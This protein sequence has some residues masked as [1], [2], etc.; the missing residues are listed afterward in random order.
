[1]RR[2]VAVGLLMA[3]AAIAQAGPTTI[4]AEG[5]IEADSNVQRLEPKGMEQPDP[6]P[7]PEEFTPA[8]ERTAAPVARLGAK[9]SHR[10]RVLNGG[11]AVGFGAL[12][13]TVIPMGSDSDPDLS[14]ENVVLLSGDFRWM[15]RIG[16]RAVSAGFDLIGIDAIPITDQYGSRTFRTLGGDALLALHGSDDRTLTFA[17]GGRYFKYKP[18]VGTDMTTGELLFGDFDWYGPTASVRLDLDLWRDVSGASSLEVS[19][20]FG[21]EARAYR[22]YALAYNCG[23]MPIVPDP[24]PSADADRCFAPTNLKRNDRYQR[25]ALELTWTGRVVAAAT[26][27]ISVTDSNSYGQS[28]MRHRATLSA[29]T[30]LPWSLHGTALATLQFDRYP[31]GLPNQDLSTL[32]FLSIDDENRS[33]LQARIARRISATWSI[34]TRG[35]IWRDLGSSPDGTFR[36]SLLYVGAIYSPWN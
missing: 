31:D 17:F 11:Y 12:S 33:S 36:R 27:Q 30:N 34:E 29:T 21:F 13:R 1:M 6:D 26:Y 14:P 18:S 3:G 35:A 28:L 4:T 8:V 25:A 9:A 20:L 22:G 15:R 5:G 32:S 24:E 10:G 7:P 19:A 2:A 23:D 16:E